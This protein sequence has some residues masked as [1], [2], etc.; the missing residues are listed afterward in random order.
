MVGSFIK[1]QRR[2]QSWRVG[3]E[4]LPG[5]GLEAELLLAALF[6]SPPPEA[7]VLRSSFLTGLLLAWQEGPEGIS[8]CCTY[9]R[10]AVSDSAHYCIMLMLENSSYKL[11]STDY[12]H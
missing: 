8:T 11:K 9:D 5:V 3:G 4:E 1:T 6:S 12:R 7:A 10:N 2:V